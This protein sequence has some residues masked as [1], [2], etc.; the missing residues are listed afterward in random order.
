MK[1]KSIPER[2]G[3]CSCQTHVCRKICIVSDSFKLFY[4]I[5]TSRPKSNTFYCER[6]KGEVYIAQQS[7]TSCA[8]QIYI[9]GREVEVKLDSEVKQNNV[10]AFISIEPILMPEPINITIRALYHCTIEALI[11]I[12]NLCYICHL[13]PI[14]ERWLYRKHIGHVIYVLDRFFN[15][16]SMVMSVW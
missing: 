2:W 8:K 7:F 14:W 11:H 13:W 1:P 9:I 6:H 12:Q 15:A 3:D 5:T 10:L 16:N 4:L